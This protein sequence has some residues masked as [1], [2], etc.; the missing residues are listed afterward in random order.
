MS[1]CPLGEFGWTITLDHLLGYP[2][3]FTY[4][5]CGI[6]VAL[7]LVRVGHAVLGLLRDLD[8][9][10]ASHSSLQKPQRRTLDESE[11]APARSVT[12]PRR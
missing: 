4:L 1:Y 11:E 8:D 6:F 5:V 9:Y 12:A 2:E 3:L 7:L 10:R